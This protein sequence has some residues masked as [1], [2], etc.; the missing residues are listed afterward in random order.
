[1]SKVLIVTGILLLVGLTSLTKPLR[2]QKVVVN[3]VSGKV[4]GVA[5]DKTKTVSFKGIPFA[6]PPVGELR[7]R[8]PQ[9]AKPWQDVRKA[10]RLSASC[11]Q[12]TEKEHLPWT[13]EFMT[14]NELSE[15]CL[16]LNVWTPRLGTSAKLPVLVFIHGGGFG[17]GSGGIA[18]Y[19]GEQLA[20]TGV[21]VVTINYRVGVFGFL[22]RP[23]LTSE[24]QHH[25][26]GNYGLMDQIAALRW[27]NENVSN[28]GGD[29]ARVTIWGQS[30]GAF[31]VQDLI[32]SPLAAGLFS[33]AVA[34]SGIGVAG[35]PLMPLADAE[36]T[37]VKFA[38]S[39]HATSIKEL[40]AM[41]AADLLPKTAF[42]SEERWSPILDGWILPATPDQLSEKGVD[43]DVPIMTGN[44]ANDGLLFASTISRVADYEQTAQKIYGSMTPEFLK[45]YPA[46][47]VEEARKMMELSTRDRERAS[48]YV[49]A[50]QRAKNHHSPVYTYFFD[51]AIPWP[52]HP[53]FGAFHT[54]EIPYFFRNLKLLDRPYEPADFKVLELASSYLKN[55]AS[56]GDPNGAGLPQWPAAADGA[57]LT[58]E[59]GSD[60]GAMPVA[61]KDRLSFWVRFFNSKEA[62]NAPVF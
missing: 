2:A 11:M 13:S 21:V 22:A 7:W 9:P 49:W 58:I 56:S 16:Y 35:L 26:S 42:F 31:S 8:A 33:R 3:T 17:G 53:E 34:N 37:G 60:T 25:S 50:C 6:A 12:V 48:A 23:D 39:R 14:Q 40:R 36:A 41:P 19:D 46:K 62:A 5:S 1:M 45:L 61:D 30:A 52:Q 24:S 59:I 4:S 43:N 51:R 20:A 54:G 15:D 10:N 44:M 29:P 32:A 18:I 47:D 55:F 57:G 28:F 27:V 38:A